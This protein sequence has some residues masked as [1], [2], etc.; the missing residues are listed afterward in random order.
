MYIEQLGKIDLNKMYKITTKE[1]L[2]SSL[3]VEYEKFA[4]PRLPACS[5]KA[6]ALIETSC[7]IIDLKGV[8]LSN[9]SSAVGYVREASGI[10]QSMSRPLI[11]ATPC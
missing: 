2:L 11:C 3:V 6:D 4:D 7:T 1:R 5:R 9:A 10:S 8:G